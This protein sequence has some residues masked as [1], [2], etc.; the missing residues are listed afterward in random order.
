MIYSH[1]PLYFSFTEQAA[2]FPI[3]WFSLDQNTVDGTA[4][5]MNNY[6]FFQTGYSFIVHITA[7]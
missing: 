5:H 6:F 2:V 1:F 4:E 7:Q 3:K